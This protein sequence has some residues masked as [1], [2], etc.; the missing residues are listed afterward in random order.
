[1][2]KI[3]ATGVLLVALLGTTACSGGNY[4][5]NGNEFGT[6]EEVTPEEQAAIDKL[7]TT[8]DSLRLVLKSEELA[9]GI[10][11]ICDGNIRLYFSY[12]DTGKSGSEG[13]SGVTALTDVEGCAR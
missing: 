11:T 13:I 8:H 2:K 7:Q 6:T 12:D 1:M 4:A 3:M 5:T 9:Y 10:Y